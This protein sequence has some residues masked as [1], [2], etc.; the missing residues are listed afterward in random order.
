MVELVTADR[1]DVVCLQEVPVWALGH[2]ERWSGMQSVGAVARR[3]RL[4]SAEL[5]RV[6]TELHHGVLRSAFSGE[7][8]AILVGPHLAID[9]SRTRVMSEGGL[10]RIAHGVRLDG[11]LYVVNF[12]I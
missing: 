9:E 2:L 5:G 11:E 8:D 10:R 12:H 4:V 7:A 6:V 3:P 1:P